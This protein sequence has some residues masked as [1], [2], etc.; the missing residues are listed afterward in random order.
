MKNSLVS[1]EDAIGPAEKVKTEAE[2]LKADT[3]SEAAAPDAHA[4]PVA[5]QLL[6]FN[7]VRPGKMNHT[8]LLK[9]IRT[10]PAGN[11]Q[12][13]S[14]AAETSQPAVQSAAVPLVHDEN[15]TQ[16][17]MTQRHKRVSISP[18]HHYPSAHT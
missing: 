1:R 11:G 17:Q 13:S 4:I 8:C 6:F 2:A 9:H 3:T 12:K 10:A 7:E 16:G 15:E 5:G 18:V 14:A